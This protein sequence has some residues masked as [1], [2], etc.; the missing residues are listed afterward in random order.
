MNCIDLDETLSFGNVFISSFLLSLDEPVLK[1]H[2]TIKY[3]STG[4]PLLLILI[5]K[6]L[7][8]NPG[9]FCTLQHC[10]STPF[11]AVLSQGKKEV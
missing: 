9:E 5:C 4:T 11:S 10:Q 1:Y 8:T 2:S 7:S 6:F 3:C